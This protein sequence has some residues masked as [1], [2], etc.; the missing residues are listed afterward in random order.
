[1]TTPGGATDAVGAGGSLALG[2]GWQA[3]IKRFVTQP[4]Q[5]CARCFSTRHGL[6]SCPRMSVD[7]VLEAES[8]RLGPTVPDSAI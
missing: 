2:T 8:G 4:E 5:V 3:V 1:M 6:W 7:I